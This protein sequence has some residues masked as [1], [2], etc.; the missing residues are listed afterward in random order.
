MTK[1]KAD[2]LHRRRVRDYQEERI[3]QEDLAR[4]TA[5]GWETEYREYLEEHPL[6][7]FH[8]WLKQT[9]NTPEP[10]EQEEA[11]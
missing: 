7:T 8:E 6:I 3:R 9:K 10:V 4:E 11:A 5:N 2:C 1:C